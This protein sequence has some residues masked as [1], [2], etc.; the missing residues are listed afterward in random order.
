MKFGFISVS[1]HLAKV[2]AKDKKIAELE[3]QL[4]KNGGA[5]GSADLSKLTALFGDEAKEE[6]FDLQ[7]KVKATL[8]YAQ[9]LEGDLNTAKDGLQAAQD[10]LTAAT[11]QLDGI[12]KH[13]GHEKSE[14]LDLVKMVGEIEP[15]GRKTP[16]V[17]ENE[18]DPDKSMKD[19]QDGEYFT[20]FDQEL[21][22]VKKEAG[23]K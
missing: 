12:A 9:G 22:D 3:E 20:E 21:A 16:T 23:I 2:E 1:E 5:D 11:E 8:D 10:G 6:G 13:L 15:E 17:K 7:S 18:D 14:G 19:A 4:K